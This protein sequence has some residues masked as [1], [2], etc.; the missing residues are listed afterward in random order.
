[1]RPISVLIALAAALAATAAQAKEF[2]SS[3]VQPADYP[4]V[5]AVAYMGK[6]ISERTGG[7]HGIGSL[8]HDDRDSESYT[9]AEVRTGVLDMARINI[10]PF[11]NSVPATIVPSLPFLF[12]STA[13][14]RQVLDGPIGEEILAALESQGLVGLCF[15]DTSARSI[16]S[17]KK[18]IRNAADMKGLNIRV[19]QSRVWVTMMQALGA[20]ATPMSFNQVHAALAGGTIDAAENNLPSYVASRHYEVG[21]I[22]SLT[23]HAATPSVVVFSKRVWDGLSGED[24]AIIR[25]AARES[26]PYM[27]KLW[28]ERE[29]SARRTIEAAG[30]QIVTDIDKKSFFDILA[31]LHSTV[32]PDP[33]LR[34]MA[35]RIQAAD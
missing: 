10:A 25:T 5:Q 8:G 12:K 1:M 9:I 18:P 13:H 32:L 35:R 31:P 2:R 19:Q 16:Y 3:D 27:R 20:K 14:M 24:Q 4:T 34:D 23:E 33:R 26:V 17:V 29:V 30:A 28:D 7:R 15:Y 6:L 11:N 21:K 22:Y